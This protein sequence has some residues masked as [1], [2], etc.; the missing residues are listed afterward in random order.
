MTS[1]DFPGWQPL[2]PTDPPPLAD[3]SERDD[4]TV[5]VFA[6]AVDEEDERW[7]RESAAATTR[8]WATRAERTFLMDLD[9][10]SPGLHRTL[11]VENLEGTADLFLFGSSL[12]RV[13]QA[14]DGGAF[15]FAP[16]GTPTADPEAV[17][18]HDRWERLIRGFRDVGA[19]LLLYLPLDLPGAGQVLERADR[20]VVLGDP[21]VLGASGADLD[22]APVV[23]AFC[24]PGTAPVEAESAEAVEVVDIA[25]LAP[26]GSFPSA[27]PRE[28]G[29]TG[30]GAES[31][32]LVEDEV[33]EITD[34]APDEP[35]VEGELDRDREVVEIAD[36][37]PDEVAGDVGDGWASVGDPALE[38][39]LAGSVD[40]RDAGSDDA[41]EAV[42]IADLAPDPVEASEAPA[43]PSALAGSD[44]AEA[45]GEAPGAEDEPDGGWRETR[46]EDLPPLEDDLPEGEAP[47]ASAEGDLDDDAL[48]EE[49]GEVTLS[50]DSLETSGE[51]LGSGLDE[52]GA[53][54]GIGTGEEDLE[55]EGVDAEPDAEE[56]EEVSGVDELDVESEEPEGPDATVPPAGFDAGD[57]E[58]ALPEREEELAGEDEGRPGDEAPLLED[59]ASLGEDV[60]AASDEPVPERDGPEWESEES[61]VPEWDGTEP[62]EDAAAGDAEEPDEDAVPDFGADLVTGADFGDPSMDAGEERDGTDEG[63]PDPG[64]GA[65][66]DASVAPRPADDPYA[67]E[68][69]YALEDARAAA[70]GE[71]VEEGAPDASA[72]AVGDAPGGGP[73]GDAVREAGSVSEEPPAPVDAASGSKGARPRV[74][75]FDRNER[76]AAAGRP[77]RL[78]VLL[79]L[80]AAGAVAAHWFGLA[81]VPGLDRGLASLL[82]PAWTGAPPTVEVPAPVP[83]TD[84][85]G[86]SLFLDGYRDFESAED[87]AG[88]LREREPDGLFVVAPLQEGREV[89]HR[90]LA[91]PARTEEEAED[92]RARLAGVLTREDPASWQVLETPLAFLLTE[93]SNL[94]AAR[95]RASE[96][97]TMEIPAYVLQVDYPRETSRYRVYAGAYATPDEARALRGLLAQSGITDA[98][99]TERQGRIPE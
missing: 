17:L 73:A 64:D 31:R 30:E 49:L 40:D 12:Q 43:G 41:E 19:T 57:D 11:E 18:R 15:F 7:A 51:E 93:S 97:R 70:S 66:S 92:L 24:R 77:V 52:F 25:E 68:D 87:V 21:R 76:D 28:F 34:L 56:F 5:V 27:E 42:D 74:A 44:E 98:T 88:A 61:D 3:A 65:E 26:D 90:L 6:V 96:L 89:Q 85:L 69:P 86:F 71:G 55:V 58:D 35:V 91:G 2:D 67:E 83:E 29:P 53:S 4:G 33:V 78:F 32:E 95:T 75:G 38:P 9:L 16:A 23:S 48:A 45:F 94:S 39:P 37:A 60:P 63:L 20:V 99:F 10:E 59:D 1:S 47:A 46:A 22:A 13:A 54:E 62:D 79:L 81:R 72:E 50:D 82:G 14:V 84:V 80:V 36:L 8:S